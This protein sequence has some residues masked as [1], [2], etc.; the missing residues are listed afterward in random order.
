[1]VTNNKRSAAAAQ[2]A[3]ALLDLANQQQAEPLG[4]ELD[5]LLQ[6]IQENPTFG[7]FLRDPAIGENER[8]QVI[9]RT[10]RGRVSELTYNLL[11]VLNRKGRLA[12][13]PEI[14][15]EYRQLLDQQLGRIKADV[16]VAEP[17][18]P[19]MLE[20]VRS[21]ISAAFKK[22]ATVVQRIDGSI[23]GGLV[24]RVGDKVIDGSIK[25]QLQAM[26]D[27]LIAAAPRPT[28]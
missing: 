13:L 27:R 28:V 21:Q 7:L 26:K 16:T 11:G 4:Q 22:H 12:L 18:D 10:F 9:E 19:A 17:L 2:Y 24:V 20:E 6:L 5:Q 25:A 15:E 14:A 8:Q 23:V 1:M 3:Q